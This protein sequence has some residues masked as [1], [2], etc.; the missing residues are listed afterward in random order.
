[1]TP[2]DK[3]C[4]IQIYKNKA[5]RGDPNQRSPRGTLKIGITRHNLNSKM[6]QAFST[7]LPEI[8]ASGLYTQ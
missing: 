5:P 8:K 7:S 6:D 2:F 3:I 4:N 1:M